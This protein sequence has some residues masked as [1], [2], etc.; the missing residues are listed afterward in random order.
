QRLLKYVRP[1]WLLF[2]LALVAML[3]GAV[4]ETAIGA[5]LVPIFNQFLGDPTLKSKTLFDLSSA[6]P[7]DDW[8]RAWITISV[9]LVTF[10]VLKGVA[11][12]FSSYLMAKIGQ[13]AV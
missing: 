2:V 13:S 4:F 10:T 11:E 6:I 7:R 3:L 12:F 1:Y 5:M 9:M 8:H